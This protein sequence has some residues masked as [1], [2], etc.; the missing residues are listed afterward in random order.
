MMCVPMTHRLQHVTDVDRVS[1]ELVKPSC[2]LIKCSLDA[3]LLQ[4]LQQQKAT[5]QP[6]KQHK[7][8]R[9]QEGRVV[10]ESWMLAWLDAG[11]GGSEAQTPSPWG[12]HSAMHN[13]NLNIKLSLEINFTDD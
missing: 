2:L 5:M 7:P 12:P 3:H 9:Q 1:T 13:Q 10:R 4:V 6:K 8:Q 11:G